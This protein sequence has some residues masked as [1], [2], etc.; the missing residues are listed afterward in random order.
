M[1][2][3]KAI[4]SRYVNVGTPSVL[5]GAL[6]LY[7]WVFPWYESYVYDPHWGH[8][9]AEAL[10]FF[11]VGLA[12]FNRRLLS[13]VLSLLAALLILPASLELLPHPVTAI[14][15]AVLAG[16]TILDMVVERKRE[17]DLGQPAGRRLTFWL[18]KH[19]PRFAYV[20]LGHLA[21]IY[22]LV[23]LPL[24]TYETDL[25]T[26]VYDAMSIVFV[27]FALL[28]EPVPN[29]W[30]MPTA[31]IG[32]F[33]GMLTMI[34]SLILLI[35]QPETWVCMGIVLVVTVLAVVAVLRDRRAPAQPAA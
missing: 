8:N 23:R 32:F 12:Y 6:W 31:W 18:K 27:V 24:G 33:W 28:E 2:R 14:I 7:L 34:V 3:F 26:K 25:V 9:Y 30:G 22:F 21:L 35:N 5:M 15:G 10:A 1:D 29:L 20:M 4:A 11:V 19:L 13:D 16:L 17:T